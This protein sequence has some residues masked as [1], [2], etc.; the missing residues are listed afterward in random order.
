[1]SNQLPLIQHALRLAQPLL[2]RRTLLDAAL[3]ASVGA[4]CRARSSAGPTPQPSHH[5]RA[6][7][8]VLGAGIAGLAAARTLNS[9]GVSVIVL[10][11]RG[12]IGGRILTDRSL[13]GI[14][15]DLGASWI[16]G[17]EKNPIAELARQL[18][19]STRLSNYESVALFDKSGKRLSDREHQKVEQRFRRLMRKLEEVQRERIV[20]KLPDL[21]LSDAI[22]QFGGSEGE[23]LTLD[24]ELDFS[25]NT[26][27]EHEFAADVSDL[28]FYHWD[29]GEEPRGGDVLFRGGYDQI[30]NHLSDRLDVRLT[31]SVQLIDTSGPNVRVVTNQGEFRAK[32][33]VVTLPLGVLKAGVIAFTPTLPLSKLR[34]IAGLGTGALNKVYL[35]FSDAFWPKDVDVISQIATRKGEWSEAYNLQPLLSEPI[36]VCLNAGDYGQRIEAMPDHAIVGGAMQMLRRLF[37]PA[38]A[39]PTGVVIT[40]WMSDPFARGSYSHCP[41]G[42]A[43]EDYEALAQPVT[44]QLFFAGEATSRESPAT[45]HGAYLSGLR[46][47]KRIALAIAADAHQEAR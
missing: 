11:A 40:R 45:V 36:L 47:A 30:V 24:A 44:A 35:R 26:T 34:A 46:E 32:R 21:A 38:I 1:M 4:A 13:S 8:L 6:D 15:L 7:V 25:I 43:I 14:P 2:S 12:R 39:D 31:H 20:K 42:A 10:E 33:V 37:G 18:E 17:I 19:L 9:L 22:V 41:P 5:D 27:I 16:H 28:S 29:Q 23:P 3:W